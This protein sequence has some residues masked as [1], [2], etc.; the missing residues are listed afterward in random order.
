VQE[1]TCPGRPRARRW[2]GSRSAERPGAGPGGGAP[3]AFPSVAQRGAPGR[4]GVVP[5]VD[6]RSPPRSRSVISVPALNAADVCAGGGAA[7]ITNGRGP[8]PPDRQV[9]A[10]TPSADGGAGS[11][12]PRAAASASNTGKSSPPSPRGERKLAERHGDGC[13]RTSP[14]LRTANTR[15]LP[16]MLGSTAR[17]I[18]AR[19]AEAVRI[20]AAEERPA[21]RIV[22]TQ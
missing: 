17:A 3:P 8:K 16:G 18:V 19:H 1:P 11:S 6:V 10:G 9:V 22:T 13:G 15:G 14:P 7:S 4:A 21:R 2:P 5:D 20:K 12:S